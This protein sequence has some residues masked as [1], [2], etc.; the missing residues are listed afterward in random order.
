MT[1]SRALFATLLVLFLV[2]PALYARGGWQYLGEAHVDGRADHDNISAE[3]EGRFR[4]I[5][6]HVQNAPVEFDHVVVHYDNGASEEL[7][8]RQV[9]PAGGRT[10]D[11]DLRGG[12]RKIRSVELYYARAV[13]GSRR[14]VVRLFGR[15]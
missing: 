6:L 12:A 14:P 8:V 13:P 9:I 11:I 2:T 5:Q 15:L 1:R 7:H 10:R 4:F 3:H